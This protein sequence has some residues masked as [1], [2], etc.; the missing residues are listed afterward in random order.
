MRLNAV[1]NELARRQLSLL[2]Y[3]NADGVTNNKL[4]IELVLL[5]ASGPFG[6]CRRDKKNTDHINAA[7]GLIS[8]LNGIVYND[9][10][11]GLELF[12]K[13]KVYFIPVAA[14]KI[15]IWSLNLAKF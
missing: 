3:Y 13:L 6:K 9:C 14:E 2:N 15:R 12:K 7:Y 11:A 8:M 5:E 1:K 10:Y 4:N